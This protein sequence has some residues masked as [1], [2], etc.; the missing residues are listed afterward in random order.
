MPTHTARPASSTDI[1]PPSPLARHWDL[2]PRIVFLNHGSFGATP[3]RVLGTQAMWRARMESEPVRFFVEDHQNVMDNAR[4]ALGDFLACDW[5]CLALLPNATQAVATVLSHLRETGFLTA[6]SEILIPDHE[7]PAC[8]NNARHIARLANATT[9]TAPIPFPLPRDAKA[10]EDAVVACVMDKVTPQTRILLLSNVTSPTGLILPIERII[11]EVRAKRGDAV[12]IIIDAAHGIGFIPNLRPA[13]TGADYFT[14]NCHKWLCAPKGTAFLWV[15]R[16][17]RTGF[18]PMVLSNNAEKPKPGRDHFLTEFDYI[19]TTDCTAFYAIPDTIQ[20]IGAMVQGGWPEAIRR[21]HDLC[22][23]GRDILCAALNIQPTA[24]DTMVGSICS[25]ILPEHPPALAQH[26]RT[27]PARYGDALQDTLLDRWHIQ[28][29]IW[30]WTLSTGA[31]VRILRISAQLHNSAAQYEYLAKAV[32]EEL[33]NE[34]H[35]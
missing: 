32:K 21:N 2:D 11:K 9:I 28:V 18:R 5:D 15:R 35:Q 17:L 16:D 30:N 8:A 4:R 33:N 7:Y 20:T 14:S 23:K 27:R 3:R 34:R 19:G 29:P 6:G 12:R 24:P 1:P 31:T 22:R 10:A 26:L 13:A 25:M